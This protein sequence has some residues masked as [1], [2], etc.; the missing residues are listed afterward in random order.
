VNYNAQEKEY[1]R[2]YSTVT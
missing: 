1:G 2:S